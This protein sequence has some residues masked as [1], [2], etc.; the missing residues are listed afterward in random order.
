M[1]S[2]THTGNDADEVVVA[3]SDEPR[4]KWQKLTDFFERLPS[5]SQPQEFP[6]PC[7]LRRFQ[8]T[9]VLRRKASPKHPVGRPKKSTSSDSTCTDSPPPPDENNEIEK[10]AAKDVYQ[11]YSLPKIVA[12][13]CEHTAVTTVLTELTAW[14]T[15]ALIWRQVKLGAYGV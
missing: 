3:E 4:S 14:S 5:S 13:A 7:Y 9:D 11:S 8:P 15:D 1:K 6:F 12:Y 10:G 2:G